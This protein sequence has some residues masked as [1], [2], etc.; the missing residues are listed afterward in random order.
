M[1]KTSTLL[2]C[3]HYGDQKEHENST[4]G[5]AVVQLTVLTPSTEA[6]AVTEADVSP[7]FEAMARCKCNAAGLAD[8]R[9]LRNILLLHL[10][11]I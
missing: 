2:T 5:T 6:A 4:N 11:Q 9:H 7:S 1:A 10:L 8:R 3:A